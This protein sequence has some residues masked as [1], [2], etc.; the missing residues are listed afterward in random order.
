MSTLKQPDSGSLANPNPHKINLKPCKSEEQGLDTK[1]RAWRMRASNE[2]LKAREWS[3]GRE[4]Y[5]LRGSEGTAASEKF[6]NNYDYSDQ[7]ERVYCNWFMWVCC[8]VDCRIKLGGVQNSV[9]SR[10]A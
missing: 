2:T 10:I 7:R 9:K 6:N 4:R 8:H 1:G 3:E 5:N